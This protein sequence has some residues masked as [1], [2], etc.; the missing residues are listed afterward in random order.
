VLVELVC[1]G[2]STPA[3]LADGVIRVGGG[4]ADEIRISGLPPALL[5]LRIDGERLT[6]T[7]SRTLSIG[8]S[9]F[10]AHVPRLVVAGEWVHLSPTVSLR[11]VP[12]A[13]RTKGTASVMRDLLRGE[14]DLLQTRAARLTCL[15]GP[16]AGNVAPIAFQQ[17]T[18]GRG[19]EC[20]LQVRDRAVSR[21]HAKLVQRDGR[22]WLEDLRGANGTYV[23]GRRVQLRV[24]LQPGDV[25]ELG[26]TL[27]RYD[28]PA[29]EQPAP[30]PPRAAAVAVHAAPPAPSRWPGVAFACGAAALIVAIVAALSALAT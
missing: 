15:T 20:T 1:A 5:R 13:S 11:Q 8:R 29:V 4:R 12:A 17:M 10:A 24:A 25:I 16:D 14:L 2:E 27:L 22:V 21:K 19:D 6:V 3:D 9:M 7:A 23:N 30:L 26:Q 18:L 28:A